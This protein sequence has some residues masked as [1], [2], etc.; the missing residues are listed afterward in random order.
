[1]QLPSARALLTHSI[2]GGIAGQAGAVLLAGWLA[3]SLLTAPPASAHGT[4]RDTPLGSG[5]QLHPDWNDPH[6]RQLLVETDRLSSA[7]ATIRLRLVSTLVYAG[8]NWGF[9]KFEV[10]CVPTSVVLHYGQF[11][12]EDDLLT[13]LEIPSDCPRFKVE[14]YNWYGDEFYLDW[15]I[16]WREHYPD[17]ATALGTAPPGTDQNHDPMVAYRGDPT[18]TLNGS[19]GYDRVDVAIPGRGPA[20]TF[21]RSYNSND[22]RQHAR[23]GPG[24]THSY[25]IRLNDPDDATGDVVLTTPRGRADRYTASG[26]TY[27]PP[28]GLDTALVKNGDDTWTATHASQSRWEFDAYGRLTAISDRYGVQSTLTYD[29]DDRLSTISDPN[30]RGSLSLT[31]DT[32][33]RLW[34]VSDWLSPARVVEY[35]YDDYGRLWKVIDREG[36]TTTYGYDGTSLRL[37]T[38]TDANGHVAVTNTY[39]GS[40][41]VSTQ[42]DARGL[43]SGGEAT[44]FTYVTNG[45]GT[46]TTTMTYP[47]TSADPAWQPQDID[48][49]DTAGRLTQ[50]ISK[51]TASSSTDI[52]ESFAYDGNGFLASATDGRGNTTLFCYDIGLNGSAISGSRGNLT[53][54]IAP[55]PAGGG[56]KL[57]TLNTYDAKNNLTQ[58]IPPKGVTSSSSTSCA[59]DLSAALDTDFAT[60]YAYDGSGVKLLSVTTRATDPDTSTLVTSTTKFEYDATYPELVDKVIPPRGNTGGSPDYTYATD[61]DYFGAGSKAGFL[62][63]VTT[64]A[65]ASQYDYDNVGRRTSMVDP[66]SKTWEYTFDK[67]DR[68]LTL[69]APEPATGVGQLVTTFAYDDVGNRLS[70]TD[71]NGTITRYLYDE[72]DSLQEVQQSASLADPSSDASKIRTEYQ[73]DHVG[74][75]TRVVR[76]KGDGTYERA[77]DYLYDGLNRVTK[78]TQ[79][80]SWPTTTPTL[81]TQF[82]YDKNSNRITLVDPLSQTTTS[83]YD[84]VNRL[85]GIDYSSTGTPDVTYAY[86]A[87]SNRTS[88]VDGTGTTTYS[89][90]ELDRLLSVAAPGSKTVSYRYDRDGNRTKIVYPDA[91]AVT[92]AIDKAGRISSL[93]DW[94]SRVTNYTYRADSQL[95]TATNVNGTTTDYSYDNASRLTQVWNKHST[96]TISRH[97]YALDKVGNRTQLDEVLPRLGAPGPISLTP[98]DALLASQPTEVQASLK[99]VAPM[100]EV[101]GAPF[102]DVGAIPDGDHG[103]NLVANPSFETNT[104]NWYAY[105]SAVTRVSG[106]QSGSWAARVAFSGCGGC[107]DYSLDDSPNTVSIPVQGTLYTATAWVK[108]D[109]V[110]GKQV[111]ITVRETGGANPAQNTTSVPVVL[112]DTWQ[113]IA[114][115]H[116]VIRSDRTALEVYVSQAGAASGDVFLADAVTLVAGAGTTPTAP[117]G[118]AVGSPTSNSLTLSWTDNATN[119]QGFKVERKISGTFVQVASVAAN[120]TSYTDAGLSGATQY[121]YRVRAY[122]SDGDSAPTSDVNGTTA[123]ALGVNLIANPSFESNLTGW[124][125]YQSSATRVAGGQDG[126]WA[127]RV[128]FSG[129]GG[130]SDY[131]LD[132]SPNTVANPPQGM[133]FTATA[134][135]KADTVTGKQVKITIR[136]NG[137]ATASQNTQSAAVTLS[138][139]WQQLTVTRSVA[140]ADRTALEVY[141]SQANAVA[142]DVFLVDNVT[143]VASGSRLST[144]VYTYDKLYRLAGVDATDNTLDTAYTY[145]PVGNRLSRT[146]NGPATSYSYDRADRITSAG[147]V[148]YTVNANGNVTARGSDAFGYDQANR[149]TSVDQTGTANDA[150]YAYDGDGKRFSSTVNAVTTRF[151]Y[152]VGGGLPTLLDDGTRKYVWGA[153]GLAYA[154]QGAGNGTVEVYHTD[155]LGSV[156]AISDGTTPTPQVM[157]IY[158]ADEFG[159]PTAVQGAVGQPMQFTGEQRDAETS[160]VYLRARMYDPQVG[161]FLQRDPFPGFTAL[162]GTM[163]RYAYVDNNPVSAV[164]PSGL[165]TSQALYDA[166]QAE[167]NCRSNA[168]DPGGLGIGGT[169]LN[170]ACWEYIFN[171]NVGLPITLPGGE[172]FILWGP[173]PFGASPGNPGG[174]SGGSSDDPA[175]I[176][177]HIRGKP[178]SE[179]IAFLERLGLRAEHFMSTTGEKGIRFK[180]PDRGG[181]KGDQVRVMFGGPGVKDAL[182]SGPR[183]RVTRGGFIEKDI[184]LGG[185]PTLGGSP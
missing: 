130:C 119:E 120:S 170:P 114:V 54:I 37:S 107:T 91:A 49:Y 18:N 116:T 173:V 180:W 127:A 92:Y 131:S 61:L 171:I 178:L 53:R 182:H 176:A 97:T 25:A 60:D 121:T 79:Y 126:S 157:Q 154:V 147:S 112:S 10:I 70:A 111:R 160:L 103:T 34:K 21:A 41:R 76:A 149:L 148:S 24:W 38:I 77:T 55:V 15:N 13:E 132:D 141:I 122:N 73:Y 45:D 156:R 67:E 166:A 58:T 164:D 168:P 66:N 155:G 142:A 153:N 11:T 6:P 3:V 26:G 44:T 20:L 65:G 80:P 32:H 158:Q 169:I 23:L 28:A 35:Q 82:M 145:D 93:T 179:V 52:T 63:Q 42:K 144:N 118:L 152:D 151:V 87:N 165:S 33:G 9:G 113:P 106:G 94:A 129:C 31:Y 163:H 98:E 174:G 183:A 108:A 2:Q 72:R 69:K 36:K 99:L 136:E 172:P 167:D 78:E 161:R 7:D 56:T 185:N 123:V 90:D 181:A 8:Q 64:P 138:G 30:G 71:P 40:G 95:S 133:Q 43:L 83:S 16:V 81:V 143:L 135:V 146:R 5:R 125:A 51:P 96:N 137:G 85:T 139:T 46:K 27:I 22:P 17:P 68:P 159:I 47:S 75:L 175:A 124:F 88:L 4:H 39:D 105:Q 104:A 86:D 57:V 59:T 117:S 162:P 48:T 150:T 128:A 62:Q 102:A 134:W 184:P 115:Q 50:H 19:F 29:A 101:R 140:Q 89:Y 12:K 14:V 110:L 84:A 1:M 177:K 109:G 74:N 100:A